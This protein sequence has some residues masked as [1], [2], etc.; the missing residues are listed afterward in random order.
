M[1]TAAVGI[2]EGLNKWKLTLSLVLVLLFL[3]GCWGQTEVGNMSIMLG[4]GIDRLDSGQVRV[5]TQIV[6]PGALG[7]G[8][9]SG[10]GGAP[11]LNHVATGST[12]D[13]AMTRL[14]EKP[15]PSLFVAH[16]TIVIFG[17]DYAKQGI[18]EAIDYFDRH[19]DFR[20]IQMLAVAEKCCALDV[21][22]APPDVEKISARSVR[23]LIDHQ[24]NQSFSV[25]SIQLDVTNEILSPSHTALMASIALDEK[26]KPKIGGTA[27]FDGGKLVGFL[28]PVDT[29][30]TL[31]FRGDV[32]RT[33]LA[34]PCASGGLQT[35]P[36]SQAT[37]QGNANGKIRLKMLNATARL[38]PKV[39][40][41]GLVMNVHVRGSAEVSHLCS[42][43]EPTTA[44]MNKW[45]QELN[46]KVT[47]E[48]AGSL[49]TL[50]AQ[51]VDAIG[52]GTTIFHAN[53]VEW[54]Q[55]VKEWPTLFKTLP[56]VYDVN[57]N[58]LRTGMIS[59]SSTQT[60][61]KQAY[62]PKYGREARIQ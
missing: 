38:E 61:T 18:V 60:Y 33:E 42:Q 49:R 34:I 57:L 1:K 46:R 25:R 56:V 47:E 7:G 53:P 10:A 41:N 11:Y 27:L 23:E 52:F 6:N 20:R 40:K 54:R 29:R 31:W 26:Q 51:G 39:T 24:V 8:T 15:W 30:G 43:A 5:T 62:P 21:L 14:Y 17:E 28:N 48:M 2:K 36:G 59:H 55:I 58:I 45:K 16:N 44:N 13:E 35:V 9:T 19:K 4:L 12:L 50:Q 32:R 3:P 37:S 22:Q